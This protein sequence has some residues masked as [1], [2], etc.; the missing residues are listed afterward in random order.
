L[1]KVHTLELPNRELVVTVL[2]L[3][4]VLRDGP[5]VYNSNELKELEEFGMYVFNALRNKSDWSTRWESS[6]IGVRLDVGISLAGGLYQY[7]VNET[8]PICEGDSLAGWLAQPGTHICKA[9]S[10][11]IED[12]Y[13]LLSDKLEVH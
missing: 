2:H 7:F 3:N 12:V 8:K 11:A 9:V 10:R 6:E 13:M 1:E 4:S 5:S